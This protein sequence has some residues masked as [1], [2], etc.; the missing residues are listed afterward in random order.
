MPK[1][2][3]EVRASI[4]KALSHPTRLKILDLIGSSGEICVCNIVKQLDIDQPTVSKHLSILKN[5][6]I[7]D[8]RKEGLMVFY[9][10]KIPCVAEFFRCVDNVIKA[11]IQVKAGFLNDR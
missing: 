5:A 1:D 11:D 3:Y 7:I 6:G 8:S 4:F 10:L 2:I 9:S